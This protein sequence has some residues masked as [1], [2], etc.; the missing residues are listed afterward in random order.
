MRFYIEKDIL[1]C[2]RLWKEYTPSKWLFD[3]WDYR[4]CLN[5]G[6]GYEP[7]FIVGEKN[8]E[9]VGVLPLWYEIKQNFYTFIGGTFPENNTFFMNDKKDIG[10][11]LNQCPMETLL[12]GI[13]PS[14][15]MYYPFKESDPIF[16]L[17]MKK[18]E[19]SLEKYITS[20][21]KKHRKNLRYDLKQFDI[22]KSEVRTNCLDDFDRM[23]E[24][25]VDRFGEESD[26]I[27]PEMAEGIRQ[28]MMRL[29]ERG[30]LNMITLLLDGVVEAVEIAAIHKGWYYILSG[31]RNIKVENCG[32]KMIVEHIKNAVSIGVDKINFLSTDSGWKSRWHL[33]TIP[34]YEY[35]NY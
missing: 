11:F 13:E 29:H 4:I 7:Y 9:R 31:G 28:L 26:L 22:R 27:E 1:R 35:Q 24:L 15:A 32:K 34:T 14:E 16:F 8:G 17:D 20:F 30:K 23:V 6:Y 5:A 10:A 33:D 12:T 18:Y 19:N 25:N 2:E 3:E 21:D